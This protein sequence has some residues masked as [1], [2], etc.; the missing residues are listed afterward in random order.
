[1]YVIHCT[2]Q[3]DELDDLGYT[4]FSIGFYEEETELVGTRETGAIFDS[5]LIEYLHAKVFKQSH[6]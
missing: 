3:F 5:A 2:F 1:M 4:G 6:L